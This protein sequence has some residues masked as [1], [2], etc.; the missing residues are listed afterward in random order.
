MTRYETMGGRLKKERDRFETIRK[1]LSEIF[2]GV[3]RDALT[4]NTDQFKKYVDEF[5]ELAE[6]KLKS[7]T[8]EGKKE[9]E[10]KK[11]L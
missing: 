1:G 11:N 2:K 7:W 6:G 10:R 8:I 5:V 4:R 9:L 3:S